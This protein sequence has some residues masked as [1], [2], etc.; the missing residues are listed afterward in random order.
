MSIG[1]QSHQMDPQSV[2]YLQCDLG[3]VNFLNSSLLNFKTGLIVLQQTVL[4]PCP[5][6]PQPPATAGDSSC[7][8]Q[9]PTSVPT[10]VSLTALGCFWCTGTCTARNTRD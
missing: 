9:L 1:S 10:F 7:T 5:V 6:A 3:Q 8:I 2:T 4:M